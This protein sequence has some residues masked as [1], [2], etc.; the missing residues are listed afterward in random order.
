MLQ[1]VRMG[2]T[3]TQHW[4]E[5][6]QDSRPEQHLRFQ[7]QYFDVETGLHYN[8]F[9]YYDPDVG[10]FVSQNVVRLV[11]G[12]NFYFYA[13]NPIAF[14]DPWG[15]APIAHQRNG[16]TLCIKDKFAANSPESKEQKNFVDRWNK[17]IKNNGGSMTRRVLSSQ[18]QKD[19][20]EWKRKIR[21]QCP[22]GK[23]AGHVPDAAAGGPAVPLDWMAQFPATNGYVGGIV[24][25]LPVGYS[26]DNVKLVADLANC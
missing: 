3:L 25:H 17:Q 2:N 15:M 19:S 13:A 23:V 26:Y 9:R 1:T 10:R 22:A 14:V 8:R 20:D 12:I 11:G 18:E 16:K 4:V 5:Q 7:G 21:C 24:R 6:N